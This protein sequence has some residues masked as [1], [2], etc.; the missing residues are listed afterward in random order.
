MP[1]ATGTLTTTDGVQLGYIRQ[2]SG[3]PLVLVH[4]GATDVTCFDPIL[5]ALAERF[6]VLAYDRRGRGMSGDGAAGYEV[7]REL[8]DLAEVAQFAGGGE[9][10]DVFAYSYGGTIALSLAASPDAART[11]RRLAVY[12][13]PFNVP[14]ML[15]DGLHDDVVRLVAAGDGDEALRQFV[16]RT[17]RLP[18]A[19]VDFMQ[20][21]PAWQASLAAVAT[22]DREFDTVDALAPPH[23]L[24]PHVPVLHIVGDS[25]GNPAFLA[26]AEQVAK[27]ADSVRI[28][29]IGGLPH[30]AIASEPVRMVELLVEFF[31]AGAPAA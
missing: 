31:T 5:P 7:Q 19:V 3:P 9:P 15:D 13:P 20:T 8:L 12:E 23:S 18:D 25:G 22:L 11:L 16:G 21:H 30:F 28:E 29:R 1:E 10:V 14:G 24:D 2:G 17:F 6:D 27:A 26:I 4:G